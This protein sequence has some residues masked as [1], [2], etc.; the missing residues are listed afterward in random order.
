MEGRE[1]KCKLYSQYDLDSQMDMCIDVDRMNCFLYGESVCNMRF[2]LHILSQGSA[3][4]EEQVE[5]MFKELEM[6]WNTMDFSLKLRVLQVPP[7]T[8]H[9]AKIVLHNCKN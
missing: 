1:H 9:L 7:G 5:W 4:N 8:M 6:Y 3:L 2:N